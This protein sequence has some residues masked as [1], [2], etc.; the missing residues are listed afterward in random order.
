MSHHIQVAQI[1]GPE[2]LTLVEQSLPAPGPGEVQ[3][4]QKAIGLNFIDTYLRTGLYPAPGFPFIPGFEAAGIVTAVADD[5][6]DF[7]PGDRVCYPNVLGAYTSVRNIAAN[8]LIH[9]PEDIGFDTA[10]AVMMKAMTAEFL[11]HRTYALSASDTV[12]V[13]AAAGGVGSLLCRWAAHIGATVIGTVSSD[14]KA[15]IAKANGCHHPIIYSR[16]G[17]VEAVQ[18]ITEGKGVDVVYDSVGKDTFEGSM[19]SLKRFG[20]LV[21]FGQSSGKI[22]PLEVTDLMSHG[23]IYLTRPTLMHHIEDA[24]S[25]QESAQHVFEALRKGWIQA[26]VAQ[27]Y[28]LADVQQAHRDLEARA[29]T[30]STVLIP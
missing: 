5:V 20:L 18:H 14:E 15:E 29:T 13:H 16:E 1:G 4:E 24:N 27:R 17:F 22:P 12:L 6:S 23:S 2:V 7:T 25:R 28:S 21:S 26:N 11:V 19:N 8:L 10:A 9:L 30:G 3:I